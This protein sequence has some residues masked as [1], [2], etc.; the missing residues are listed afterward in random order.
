MTQLRKRVEPWS[1]AIHIGAEAT[2]RSS[3]ASDVFRHWVIK[4]DPREPAVAD[5]SLHSAARP[6][7]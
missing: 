4:P 6:E 5:S 1:I 3:T 7:M 2:S